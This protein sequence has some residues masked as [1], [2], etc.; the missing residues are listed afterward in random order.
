MYGIPAVLTKLGKL[1][2]Q[3]GTGLASRILFSIMHV[4]SP[5]KGLLAWK[6]R[7]VSSRLFIM[8]NVSM[9]VLSRQVNDSIF[10]PELNISIEILQIK[11]KT[12]RIGID[13]PSEFRVIRG[14]LNY[15]SK[16]PVK[17]LVKSR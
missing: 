11:G 12:I 9:L 16:P 7:I 5:R 1:V 13:A 15:S 17:E 3:L 14:E 2:P 10:F 8:E 6:P 4:L